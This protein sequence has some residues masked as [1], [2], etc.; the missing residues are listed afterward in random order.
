[1]KKPVE[2]TELENRL[3][4]LY[5]KFFPSVLD[6]GKRCIFILPAVVGALRQVGVLDVE[7][8]QFRKASD[9]PAV[10]EIKLVLPLIVTLFTAQIQCAHQH[11]EL[12]L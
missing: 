6:P 8:F 12:L 5:Q 10:K 11:L 4:S 2:E 3:Y 1:M 9:M 7:L